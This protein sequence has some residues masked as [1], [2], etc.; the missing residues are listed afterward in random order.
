MSYPLCSSAGHEQLHRPPVSCPLHRS[1]H[2]HWPAPR[3]IEANDKVTPAVAHPRGLPDEAQACLL[4]V[5]FRMGGRVVECARLE[6]VCAAMHRGF[7]SLP[8]RHIAVRRIKFLGGM[9]TQ[10]EPLDRLRIAQPI[11]PH[12]PYRCRRLK[13][14]GGMRT[15]PSGTDRPTSRPLRGESR[16]LQSTFAL[17]AELVWGHKS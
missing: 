8:I 10:F 7:E 15:Q 5:R 9:R 1:L 14:L 12:P 4:P 11:P 3:R 16:R 17:Q 2:L 13:P 6:S